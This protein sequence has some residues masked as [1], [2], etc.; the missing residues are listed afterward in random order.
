MALSDLVSTARGDLPRYRQHIG[1]RRD[2]HCILNALQRFIVFSESRQFLFKRGSA[3]SN[4]PTLVWQ[5]GLQHIDDVCPQYC[6]DTWF[7]K[8]SESTGVLIP[9]YCKSPANVPERATPA[10]TC[11][12][13]PD[14]QIEIV[15]VSPLINTFVHKAAA[16]AFL[17]AA[18]LAV[19]SARA[20][21]I[22]IDETRQVVRLA[23]DSIA[24]RL[25]SAGRLHL[26]L[27]PTVA[28]DSVAGANCSAQITTLVRETFSTAAIAPITQPAQRWPTLCDNS[29]EV[30]LAVPRVA[31]DSA[32]FI[33]TSLHG[34]RTTLFQEA[35]Q[36]SVL[37]TKTAGRWIVA[38]YTS[39][40]TSFS[41]P[42]VAQPSHCAW[43]PEPNNIVSIPD[44]TAGA[45]TGSGAAIAINT[46]ESC[47]WCTLTTRPFRKLGQPTDLPTPRDGALIFPGGRS[48]SSGGAARYFVQ[49]SE[50]GQLLMFDS[51]GT[52]STAIGLQGKQ[53]GEFQTT[54]AVAFDAQ[55]S[56]Y[57]LDNELRRVSVFSPTLQFVRL[58]P[59]PWAVDA[60]WILRDGR[61]LTVR[62]PSGY[63]DPIAILSPRGDVIRS[64]GAPLSSDGLS[65]VDCG[66]PVVT[67]APTGYRLWLA[68]S[69]RYQL[70]EWDLGGRRTAVL[71]KSSVSFGVTPP[72]NLRLG[73]A[74]QMRDAQGARSPGL[75][76]LVAA[77]DGELWVAYSARDSLGGTVNMV[78]V[79]DP[80]R[81][82]LVK[83]LVG[84]SLDAV[85]SSG[86]RAMRRVNE[87]GF[88]ELFLEHYE[89]DH[90]RGGA[91][92]KSDR[93]GV[94]HDRR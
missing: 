4:R 81:G 84:A 41:D 47:P 83:T 60:F 51:T 46:E 64:F 52:Q 19:P 65:C 40:D 31:V 26:Y 49:S 73:N 67:L 92:L 5:M 54:D 23:A 11:S 44:R 57:V 8:P 15:T 87:F 75:R 85:V 7:H 34:N 22:E 13:S 86:I 33:A 42:T 94:N 10:A 14:I 21:S 56:V 89:L 50:P 3:F 63:G 45:R 76:K 36:H 61:L 9:G 6:I 17:T 72:G 29:D 78:D 53:P 43:S 18:V 12:L 77:A 62:T 28:C 16:L 37:L 88:N 58:F 66:V 2:S 55:D 25:R 90:R 24:S 71:Q 82:R 38:L 59:L 80:V 91:N 20:Q 70:E 30:R 79:L 35:T 27:S 48:G 39:A 1:S 69:N 74:D 93:R 68:W 32:Q